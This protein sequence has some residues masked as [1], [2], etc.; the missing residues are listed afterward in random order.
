MIK[1]GFS[2]GTIKENEDVTPQ[3]YEKALLAVKEIFGKRL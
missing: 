3:Q 1:T 2:W